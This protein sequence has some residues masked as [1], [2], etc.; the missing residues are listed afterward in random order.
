MT[1]VEFSSVTREQAAHQQ[2]ERATDRLRRLEQET[3][4]CF[5]ELQKA[6]ERMCEIGVHVDVQMTPPVLEAWR[7]HTQ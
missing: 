1:V 2:F 4:A 3:S 5:G 6:R 7:T